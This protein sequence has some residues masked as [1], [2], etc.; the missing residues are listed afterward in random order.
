MTRVLVV[1]DDPQLRSALG[2]EI[3]EQGYEV[4]IA[5]SVDEAVAI[6]DR[7]AIDVLL[8]DLRM[9]ERDGIDL[10]QTVRS[11]SERTRSILMSAFASARDYQTAVDL[12]VVRVLCK[13][14]TP[15]EALE[16]I[17]QAVDC[18]KGFRGSIHG[19]SL[20]DMLQMF[21]FGRRSITI[22]VAGIVPGTIH[23]RNGEVIHAERGTLSGEEA[24]RAVLATQSGS[25]TTSVL[26]VVPQTVFRSFHSLLV[27]LVRQ[28]DEA[29]RGPA[30][31]PQESLAPPRLSLFPFLSSSLPPPSALPHTV[32]GTAEPNELAKLARATLLGLPLATPIS[33]IDLPGGPAAPGARADEELANNVQEL[34]RALEPS[35]GKV[36]KIECVGDDLGLGIVAFGDVAVLAADTMAGRHA[37]IRFRGDLERV[38]QSLNRIEEKG[39]SDGKNR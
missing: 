6:L 9:S 35:L 20:V 11:R 23:V 25:V 18:E 21:H 17:E 12:G 1:D 8:T 10:L 13:P 3:A 16:A 37:A 32:T 39:D 22:N 5:S 33:V 7:S 26:G 24:L 29:E 2:R 34:L 19:L 31:A 36:R 15:R 4:E 38:A 27:D 30:G 14:F 28:L